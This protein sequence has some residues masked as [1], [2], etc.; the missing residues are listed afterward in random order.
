MIR[1]TSYTDKAESLI[2]AFGRETTAIRNDQRFTDAEKRRRLAAAYLQT[3]TETESLKTAEAKDRSDRIQ[4]LRRRIY[5]RFDTTQGSDVIALRDAQERASALTSEDQA[6]ALELLNR[7]NLNNDQSMTRA[8]L[9]RAYEVQ[10]VDVLNQYTAHNPSTERDIDELW[11][12]SDG[13]ETL[14]ATL[15]RE[16]SYVVTAPTEIASTPESELPHLSGESIEDVVTRAM[17]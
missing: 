8:L 6:R 15:H 3:K 11:T 10:W 1:L 7:A 16:W 2:A 12:L 17:S 9:M 5:G 13:G 4:A 14:A